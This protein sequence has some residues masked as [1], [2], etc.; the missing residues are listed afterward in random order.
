[1]E[2]IIYRS[3]LF[4]TGVINLI[5]ASI[6]MK[7]TR[8]YR[9]YE[10]YYRT[11]MLTALWI[12]VFG[13]GYILHGVLMWRET[14]PTA[15]SAL[16]V[17]YFHIGAICFSW[18]YTSLLN[19][20]Y[21]TRGIMVRDIAYYFFG[22]LVYWTVAMLW[23]QEP[24]FTLMSYCLYFAYAVWVVFVFYQTYN[25]VSSRLLSLSYGKVMDFVRWMQVCCDLIVLFGICSV[26]VTGMFPTDFWPY[27]LLL[28]AGVGMFAFI[29][30]SLNKYGATI[31][32]TTEA[33][34]KVAS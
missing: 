15:A 25:H 1:M 6:L 20:K 23:K 30:Y 7:G 5:M 13:L 9:Q 3:A 12:A 2:L 28:V 31:E 8:T 34:K 29:S 33:T 24:T 10:I 11:R 18:G 14:W 16:T 17:S 32:T 26:V 4:L 19:P 27:T 22:L 21:L